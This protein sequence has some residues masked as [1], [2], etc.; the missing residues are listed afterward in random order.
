MFNYRNDPKLTDGERLFPM[1]LF[2]SQ[3]TI[4]DINVRVHNVLSVRTCTRA[5][6][7]FL[8]ADILTQDVKA[9]LVTSSVS[10]EGQLTQTPDAPIEVYLTQG[11]ENVQKA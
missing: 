8:M 9:H 11:H 6:P 10:E 1:L 5:A 3:A 4:R 2:H 7:P